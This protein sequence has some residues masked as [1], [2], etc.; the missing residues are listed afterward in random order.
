VQPEPVAGLPKRTRN[1]HRIQTE[2][3]LALFQGF[4]YQL[5]MRHHALLRSL[6]FISV[7]PK[8]PVCQAK[9]VKKCVKNAY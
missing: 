5:F 2:Y 1:K 6:K 9:K 7:Y 4:F 8:K 3:A